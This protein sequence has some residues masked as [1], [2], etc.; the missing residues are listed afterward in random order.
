MAR[1]GLQ[2]KVSVPQLFHGTPAQRHTGDAAT[3]D[4]EPMLTSHHT[5]LLYRGPSRQVSG[6]GVAQPLFC[7]LVGIST[8]NTCWKEGASLVECTV[9]RRTGLHYDDF[10][11]S[12][13]AKGGRK[14]AS[15]V[16]QVVNYSS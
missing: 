11:C 10:S 15:L 6:V 12:M 7:Q 9:H 4:Q 8:W 5:S 3:D 13:A 16:L 2:I 14:L 1:A